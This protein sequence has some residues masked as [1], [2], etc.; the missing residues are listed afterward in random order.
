MKMLRRKV[1]LCFLFLMYQMRSFA[2][3]LPPVTYLGIEQ[4]LSNNV[5]TCIYQDHSGFMWFGTYDGLNRYDGYGFKVFRNIIGDN[6]SLSD[7]HVY[8]IAGDANH[9]LW[10]GA[11]KGVSIYDPVTTRFSY[12]LFKEWN[13]HQLQSIQVGVAAIT[14][15]NDGEFM[16]VGSVGKGLLVF[17][18]N[19]NTGLQIPLPNSGDHLNYSVSVF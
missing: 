6:S 7:N 10:I 18:K 16:L 11:K 1:L 14:S 4:G 15:V 12:P 17:E 13:Q 8:T 5:V 2:I 3:D 9:K 19:S